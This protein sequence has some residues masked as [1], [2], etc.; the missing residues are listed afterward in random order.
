MKDADILSHNREAWNQQVDRG[1]RWTQAVDRETVRR[2]RGGDFEIVLTPTIPVPKKWFPPLE[3]TKTL[4]LASAGGQ[5]APL[6]SAA[7]AD[8]TVLD[9]SPRQLDQDRAVAERERLEMRIVQGDMADLSIF[10]DESFDL[11]FHPCSNTF[12]PSVLP[13]WREC[14]RVLRSAGVLMS[15]FTNPIRYLFDDERKENGNLEVLYR[16]PYSD[17]DHLDAEHI[18]KAIA[19]GQPLEFGHTLQDQIGGQL[20]AGFFLTGLYEDRYAKTDTDPLSEFL[21]TF[22]ATRAI[23]L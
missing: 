5:Q 1:N 21:D 16:L 11:I 10:E 7:G 19:D 9:N 23:K 6:L 20:A 4:C 2:A 3:G 14:F 13:V 17:L 18:Q 8:V 15:G 12:V 22:I